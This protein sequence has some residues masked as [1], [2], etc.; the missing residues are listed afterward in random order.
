LRRYSS[1]AKG[2]APDGGGLLSSW[3]AASNVA[4]VP[5]TTDGAGTVPATRWG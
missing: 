1:T 4:S 2:D 5:A 3:R